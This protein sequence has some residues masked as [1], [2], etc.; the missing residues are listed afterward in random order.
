MII[1][2]DSAPTWFRLP[3][4]NLW[5]LSAMNAEGTMHSR[6]GVERVIWQGCCPYGKPGDRLVGKETWGVGRIYDG[7]PA[8]DIHPGAKVAY[9]ATGT[10]K[11][12]R[13]RPSGHM[14]RHF[15]RIHL[16]IV[17][18]WVER[19]QDISEED[20]LAS[21]FHNPEGLNRDYPDRAR[22]WF[23]ETH[24]LIHGPGSWERNEWQWCLEVKQVEGGAA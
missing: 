5:L 2:S 12:V 14:P 6:R 18:V 15:S 21:G 4:E 7:V 16:E 1:S 23:R 9:P 8:R 22:Y 24:D 13:Y 3:R 10:Y 20:A 17:R 11:G 19:L